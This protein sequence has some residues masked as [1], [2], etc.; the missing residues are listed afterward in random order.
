MSENHKK[1]ELVYIIHPEQTDDRVN[2]IAQGLKAAIEKEGGAVE[3]LEQWGKKRLAYLVQKQRYGYYTLII[4]S[5]PPASVNG[6]ELLL[7]HDEHVIKYITL[8]HD[9]RS[10]LKPPPI[11]STSF[12]SHNRR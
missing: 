8:Q 12:F 2:E 6:L 1:Y 5:A 11:E 4:L 10:A 7:K 9:P 3:H